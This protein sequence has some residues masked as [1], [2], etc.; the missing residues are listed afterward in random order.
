MQITLQGQPHGGAE[1]S[2]QAIG[3]NRPPTEDRPVFD[4]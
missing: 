3:W 1:A 2:C 4:M